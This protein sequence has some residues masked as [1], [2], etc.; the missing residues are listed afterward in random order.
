MHRRYRQC[1]TLLILE[2]RILKRT[3]CYYIICAVYLHF[4]LAN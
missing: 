1:D 2:R 4:I 3:N